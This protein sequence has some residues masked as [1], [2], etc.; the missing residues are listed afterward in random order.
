MNNT[1]GG[2][3][4]TLDVTEDWNS[5]L[6]DKVVGNTPSEQQNQKRFLKMSVV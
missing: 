5:D 4:S 1:L 6:D 2:I 3:N